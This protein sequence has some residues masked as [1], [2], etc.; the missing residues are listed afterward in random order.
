MANF[1]LTPEQAEEVTDYLR[2]TCNDPAECLEAFP[3]FKDVDEG[4]ATDAI[5]EACASA[6]IER[7]DTCS[8]WVEDNECN[9]HGVCSDCAEDEGNED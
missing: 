7:C 5:N 9:Q 6:E 8:W 1:K 4:Q 3:F 2:G